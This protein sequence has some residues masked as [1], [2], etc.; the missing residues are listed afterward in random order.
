MEV[1]ETLGIGLDP[2]SIPDY[3]A[4]KEVWKRLPRLEVRMVEQNEECRHSL[5]E[6]LVFETPYDRPRGACHAL[7]QVLQLYLWR[8]ALG[9][10]SWN[11]ADHSVYLI[12]CPDAKGTVWE[13]RLAMNASVEA[14]GSARG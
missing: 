10:P 14:V 12:H 11:P 6:V 13:L 1:D 4:Y 7:L 3:A 2:A 8:A 9:F 5:G